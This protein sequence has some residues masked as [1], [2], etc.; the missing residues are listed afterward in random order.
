LSELSTPFPLQ[1]KRQSPPKA[2]RKTA[3][4]NLPFRQTIS[5]SK[6]PRAQAFDVSVRQGVGQ[7]RQ[8]FN[9]AAMTLKEHFGN[10]DSRAE[11]S[12]NLKRRMSIEQ[13]FNENFADVIYAVL[14]V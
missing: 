9:R 10:P 2:E 13:I 7:S 3:F 12:V 4:V 11:I 6:P 8:K 5:T 1:L 14:R